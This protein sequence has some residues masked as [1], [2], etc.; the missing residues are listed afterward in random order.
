VKHLWDGSYIS[1][2][3]LWPQLWIS[4]NH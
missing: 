3:I 4:R 1:K 2:I